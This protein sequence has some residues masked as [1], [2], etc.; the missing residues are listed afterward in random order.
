[1]SVELGHEITIND[2]SYNFDITKIKKEPEKAQQSIIESK[3]AALKD[4]SNP[5]IAIKEQKQE[6][7]QANVAVKEQKRN[8]LQI[9]I[10]PRHSG[11]K[12]SR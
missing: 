8:N 11:H 10:Q 2:I 5:N 6:E 12:L 3:Q 9:N 4:K 1:V 7:Q